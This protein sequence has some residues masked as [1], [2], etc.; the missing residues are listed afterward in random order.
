MTMNAMRLVRSPLDT[1]S[2]QRWLAV[3]DRD[4]LERLLP[5]DLAESREQEVHDATDA[6][7]CLCT[8]PIDG[9]VG[10]ILLVRTVIVADA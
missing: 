6:I 8:P 2:R 1:A 10:S 7:E 4:G 9:L 3:D 5:L